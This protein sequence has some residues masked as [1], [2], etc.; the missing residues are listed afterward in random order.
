M[1]YSSFSVYKKNISEIYYEKQV[2]MFMELEELFSMIPQFIKIVNYFF[3]HS[4][5]RKRI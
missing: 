5:E 3:K 2:K 4:V 1:V